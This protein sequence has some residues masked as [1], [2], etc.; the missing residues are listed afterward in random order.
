MSVSRR[1]ADVT[2]AAARSARR[3]LGCWRR[4]G[5]CQ[6]Q[7]RDDEKKMDARSLSRGRDQLRTSGAVRAA[8]TT[9]RDQHATTRR[10]KTAR[11]N[12]KYTASITVI[13]RATISQFTKENTSQ[14][15]PSGPLQL[16]GAAV[17]SYKFV[18]ELRR[19]YHKMVDLSHFF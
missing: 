2:L 10:T 19:G 3:R 14:N 7:R 13:A 1:A 16:E 12:S 11:T 9:T 18:S 4:R 17:A 6:T 15:S 8:S 5:M